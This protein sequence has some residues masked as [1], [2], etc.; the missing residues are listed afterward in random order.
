[1]KDIR[2]EKGAITLLVLVTMVFLATVLARTY[3][4][5]SNKAQTQIEV[6][7]QTRRIYETET[8][9][10]AY[11]SFF[12][13]ELIP[14][15]TVEQ[16]LKIGLD[17][18][19]QINESGGKIYV[20]SKDASYILMDNLEFSSDDWTPMWKQS[21]SG[22]TGSFNGNGKTIRVTNSEGDVYEFNTG[23]NYR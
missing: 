15:Y 21:D 17:K 14:I 20:F 10:E 16:L 13:E 19:V 9:E 11:N 6:T 8:E 23:N 12:G 5:I 7:E 4:L 18:S 2:G 22:F 1:M 3:I